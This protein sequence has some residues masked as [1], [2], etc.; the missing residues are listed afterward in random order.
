VQVIKNLSE[1]RIFPHS[2]FLFLL[3]TFFGASSP[4]CKQEER[5]ENQAVSI[6]LNLCS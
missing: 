5:H 6:Q 2:F 1:K 4:L 3:I